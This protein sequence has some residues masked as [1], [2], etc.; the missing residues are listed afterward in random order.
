MLRKR[1]RGVSVVTAIFL[2]LVIAVLGAYIASV[3]TT[4][5]TTATLDLQGA[6]AYQAAYAGMQ[7]GVYQTL[8]PPGTCAGSTSFALTGALGGFAVTV[9]CTDTTLPLGY[10][11][12]GVTRHV[13]RITSTGCSPS[14]GA[15]PGTQGGYYVERQLEATLD[16]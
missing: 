9:Q 2:I 11:E 6:K 12:N 3:A 8:G 5:H 10:T 1:V 7:W 14:G 13:Y 16:K 4:Q 15:C